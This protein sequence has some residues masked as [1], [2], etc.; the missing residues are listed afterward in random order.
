MTVKTPQ[1][2]RKAPFL[3]DVKTR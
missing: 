2:K 3:R 1:E